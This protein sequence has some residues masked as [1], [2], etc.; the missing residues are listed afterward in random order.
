MQVSVKAHFNKQTKDSKKELVQFHVKGED[1]KKPE[2]NMLTR[3][4]VLLE[5]EGVEHK[6]KCEFSKTTK[7]SKKTVLEFIVKVDASAENTFNFYKKA[8]SDVTLHIVETQMSTDDFEDEHEGIPYSV[9]KDGTA[10]ISPDQ[11]S[12]DDVDKEE[13]ELDGDPFASPNDED[14]LD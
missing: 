3:E 2:L 10:N 5:I 8:G 6:L 13:D 9:D 4:M 11:L 1:E 12:L 7:D 14:S